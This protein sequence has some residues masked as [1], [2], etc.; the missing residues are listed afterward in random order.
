MR[1]KVVNEDDMNIPT[2]DV[3]K[4]ARL[5]ATVLLNNVNSWLF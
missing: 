1:T 3:Q 4:G 2:E 5:I